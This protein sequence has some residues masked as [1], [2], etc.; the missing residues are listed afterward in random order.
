MCYDSYLHFPSVL[1]LFMFLPFWFS[2][3]SLPLYLVWTTD[4]MFS[5][6]LDT[7]WH[8]STWHCTHQVY[9]PWSWSTFQVVTAIIRPPQIPPELWGGCHPVLACY[10]LFWGSAL[11]RLLSTVHSETDPSACPD[12]C[13]M[14]ASP[15]PT[16]VK[17]H[18]NT[19]SYS[20]FLLRS[21]LL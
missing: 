13:R 9:V 17:R 11:Q 3:W 7:A 18:I 12:F 10:G 19:Y 1:C 21:Y 8:P 2:G 15:G 14:E 6:S 4:L 20:G 16:V 5:S